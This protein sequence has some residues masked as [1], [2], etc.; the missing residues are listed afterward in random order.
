ME[1]IYKKEENGSS[2]ER[3][4]DAMACDYHKGRGHSVRR[5]LLDLCF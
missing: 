1:G 4:S 2:R 3:I 5:D